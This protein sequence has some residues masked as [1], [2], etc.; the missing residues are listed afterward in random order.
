[1]K[2]HQLTDHGLL[3]GPGAFPRNGIR[4]K[5]PAANAG[6][7]AAADAATGWHGSAAPVLVLIQLQGKLSPLVPAW[8]VMMA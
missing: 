8:S 4:A 6:C 1:M 7:Y 3:D 2:P 5:A